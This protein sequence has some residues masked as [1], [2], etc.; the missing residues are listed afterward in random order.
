[1]CNP[2]AIM[3]FEDRIKLDSRKTY[4]H[5]LGRP[6]LYQVKTSDN[7]IDKKLKSDKS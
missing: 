2:K 1:M 7:A 3:L 5:C 6:V 4:N